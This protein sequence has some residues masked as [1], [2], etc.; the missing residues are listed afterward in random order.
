MEAVSKEQA[1]A[2]ASARLRLQGA[3]NLDAEGS[4]GAALALPPKA[5]G[6]D[7]QD[8]LAAS[9][10]TRFALGAASPILGGA[11][12]LTHLNGDQKGADAVD[13]LLKR[14][15][16][17]KKRGGAEGVDMAGLAGAIAAPVGV[18]G[19]AAEG[20]NLLSRI[21]TGAKTGAVVGATTPV[22][23]DGDYAGKKTL[24]V[25]GGTLLGGGMPAVLA[26]ILGVGKAAYNVIEPWL[27]GG[28]DKVAGR[29]ANK[30]AGDRQS[31]VV[32]ALL[33]T[34]QQV[35]GSWAGPA[36]DLSTAADAAT[37]AGSAEFSALGKIAASRDP[38]AYNSIEEAQQA[39]RASAIQS[40]A[41]GATNKEQDAAVKGA[42]G[43]RKAATDPLYEAVKNSPASVKSAPVMSLVSHLLETNK[44]E[45]LL[46]RPLRDIQAKLTVETEKGQK[47]E[48][49]VPNL[50]SLS[51]DIKNKIEA[52]NPDGSPA[53]DVAALTKVKK[54]LDDAIGKAEPAYTAAR[55]KFAELSGPVN[56]LQVGAE[57]D[58][59]LIRPT[60]K[61][62]P[63]SYAAAVDDAGKTLKTAT[64]MRASSIDKVLT[65]GEVN[66]TNS[67]ADE[68]TR[69]AQTDK[70]SSA[71]MPAAK[72]QLSTALAP[73]HVPGLLDRG[74]MIGRAIFNRMQGKAGAATM[75]RL[76]E[77]MKNPQDIAA[78]MQNASPQEKSE[79][80][81]ALLL[82]RVPTI[83]ATSATARYTGG[84]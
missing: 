12:L 55:E 52:K 54:A 18:A 14:L 5:E 49:S 72:E 28:V 44:N 62:S 66:T 56:R 39:A 24:Q 51:R 30:L 2:L 76:M 79:L 53:F 27:P 32:D 11:Q 29:T 77:A 1:L 73:V 43:T 82:Q 21:S 67:V 40:I 17:M 22:T 10:L 45:D 80:L 61:E 42:M 25:V 58:S 65:P 13:A 71:G 4:I 50:V 47:L 15:E 26:P 84:H 38:S 33:N 75:D 78:L 35:P 48:N 69:R 16:E 68:L 9:P 81:K 8:A 23:G 31:D 20:A 41:G 83:G 64:G 6:V 70:L 19:K 74:V 37:P 3:P 59:K 7:T 57:L 46:T 60:G 34:R 63:T 36:K